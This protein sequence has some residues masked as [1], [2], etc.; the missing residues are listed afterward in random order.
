MTED[1]KE[2]IEAIEAQH[3]FD[4]ETSEIDSGCVSMLNHADESDFSYLFEIEKMVDRIREYK[5]PGFR[6][7]ASWFGSIP[8]E[9]LTLAKRHYKRLGDFIRQ[10]SSER[11]YTPRIRAFYD[12]CKAIGILDD[13][14][15]VSRE[16]NE[17]YGLTG[18]LYAEIFNELIE[19]IRETCQSRGFKEK[20]RFLK[21]NAKRN[22][23]KGLAFEAKMYG[24]KS[25]H[26]VLVLHF[27]YKREY[28]K[29][30]TFEDMRRDRRRFF[31]NRRT[32]RLLRGIEG[33]IWKIERGEDSGL[34]MHLIIFYSTDFR[35]D[36][37][38]AKMLGEYWVNVVTE[39]KGD[40]WN[41]NANK[42]KHERRGYGDGTGVID[43]RDTKKRYALCKTISYLAKPEQF[44][45]MTDGEQ[46]RTFGT[47]QV[48]Q[49]VKSG[50]PRID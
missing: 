10:Y 18:K 40:Y 39:G 35:A 42:D 31:N 25:R 7:R 48:P 47:S 12:A 5:Q 36:V 26:L 46:I 4:T 6:M 19:R 15:F 41:S 50:R 2:G 45:P 3:N 14:Y 27:S 28:R 33:Y 43:W 38:I 17:Y 11:F 34:H 44:L 1:F 24:W 9:P 37:I 22:Q 49:K 13:R 8:V 21:N 16:P 23:A 32:S 29:D 30:M 20:L